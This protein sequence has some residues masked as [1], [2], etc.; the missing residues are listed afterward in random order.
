MPYRKFYNLEYSRFPSMKVAI[1]TDVFLP[2]L[3][4][5]VTAVLNLAKG[6]ADKGHHVY[7]VCPTF[8]T[9][10]DFSHPNITIIRT[11]GIKASA[12]YEDFRFALPINPRVMKILHDNKIDIIHFHTPSSL[13][14][15]AIIASKMMNIP[16]V[17]TFHTFIADPGYLSYL[18][19]TTPLAQKIA[20]EY[21]N[22]FYN[23]CDLVTSPSPQTRRE[24]IENGAKK[25]IKVISNG[26]D[27]R[28]FDNT[29][30]KAVKAKYGKNSNLLLFVGRLGLEKNLPYLIE[31]FRM[32]VDK[33][34]GTKLIIVGEGPAATDVK[35]LVSSIGLND[36][37]IFT[38]R[39]EHDRL[40]KS[41]LFGACDIFVSA[42]LTENQPMT[43]LEAQANGLVCV[44]INSRG[45]PGLIKDGRN[46]FLVPNNNRQAFADAILTLLENPNL[47]AKMKNA[48]LSEIKKQ[49]INAIISVWEATYHELIRKKRLRANL[50]RD[51]RKTARNALES[52]KS[53]L[54]TEWLKSLR[55]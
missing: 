42:S 7:I 48:T 12:L 50:V 4:G 24:M 26:I 43:V 45:M 49:D 44:A 51:T 21:S 6:L 11:Q 18:K 35:D 20:W 15:Q 16:L 17:G 27:F 29:N 1:F 40:V 54:D 39:I 46:G 52:I 31:C 33:R 30:A 41:G 47:L 14:M 25:R 3:S 38:G 37:I 9:H 36:N 28:L 2:Y 22:M 5:V 23:S 8:K 13:G 32:V 55:R 53:R 34:P 10:S 19:I